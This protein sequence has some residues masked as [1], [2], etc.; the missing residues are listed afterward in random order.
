MPVSL[1]PWSFLLCQCLIPLPPLIF[2]EHLVGQIL[3]S[4]HQVMLYR[5]SKISHLRAKGTPR[6][7]SNIWQRWFEIRT[8][9]ESGEHNDI[10][11]T[12]GAF[13]SH[14][15]SLTQQLVVLSIVMIL[16]QGACG[17]GKEEG[18]EK[19]EKKR[20]GRKETR[21]K[22]TEKE[23]KKIQAK[24]R[25]RR[26][27]RKTKRKGAN[28]KG[29]EKK[30]LFVILFCLSFLGFSFQTGTRPRKPRCWSVKIQPYVWYV[31]KVDVCICLHVYK[32]NWW[33]VSGLL[34]LSKII[35]S[36]RLSDMR[37]RHQEKHAAEL[38]TWRVFSTS[39]G[40]AWLGVWYAHLFALRNI[41]WCPL[42]E[43]DL[44]KRH[45][46]DQHDTF[47]GQRSCTS[48]DIWYNCK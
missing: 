24:K 35:R 47:D 38:E 3:A 36:L 6:L 5:S 28:K 33:W 20:T 22:E 48:W 9:V 43:N 34:L 1:F 26:E 29:E 32:L 19:Q 18:E 10:N 39:H 21:G 46:V 16:A 25:K 8:F 12:G 14:V 13:T 4:S 44:M 40:D 7:Q 42:Q 41:R 30:S 23:H 45:T 15:F 11:I 2:T 31:Y 27:N 17:E 37:S